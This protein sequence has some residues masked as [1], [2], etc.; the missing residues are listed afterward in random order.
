MA[1][2]AWDEDGDGGEG[3]GGW[4]MPIAASYLPLGV[5]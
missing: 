5:R 2:V 4:H 1:D 3:G